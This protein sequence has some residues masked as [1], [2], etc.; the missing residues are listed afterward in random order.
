MP[1]KETIKK[2]KKDKREGKSAF[3]QASEFV[4]QII[5]DVHRGKHG[6]RSPKQGIAIALSEAR[7]AGIKI[8]PRKGKKKVAAKNA[9]SAAKKK[10]T[11]AR[12]AA[13]V[14]AVRTKDKAGLHLAAKKAARTRVRDIHVQ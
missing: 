1:R 5:H 4:H 2:A 10:S 14:K 6:V 12:H 11:A 8:P 13:A 3:T 9:K 7:Q